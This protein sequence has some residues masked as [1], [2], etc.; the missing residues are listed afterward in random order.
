MVDYFVIISTKL[1][2]KDLELQAFCN[3]HYKKVELF[4]F[5]CN[6]YYKID[7]RTYLFFKYLNKRK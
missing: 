4:I 2:I 5:L 1:K 3:T 7:C 6:V